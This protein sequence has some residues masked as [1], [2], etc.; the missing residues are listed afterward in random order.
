MDEALHDM[1]LFRRFAKLDL[2]RD[3]MPDE[4]TIL[5]LSAAAGTPRSWRA[6]AE[7]GQCAA[8]RQGIVVQG[9]YAG[10]CGFRGAITSSAGFGYIGIWIAPSV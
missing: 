1:A 6:D 7:D 8:V 5:Q 9:R 4:S 2:T 10:G 3:N